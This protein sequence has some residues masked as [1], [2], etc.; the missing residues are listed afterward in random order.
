MLAS[1]CNKRRQEMKQSIAFWLRHF[2]LI[3][4]VSLAALG[5]VAGCAF[6][7][8]YGTVTVGPSATG[9]LKPGDLEAYGIAFITPATVTGQEED[10]PALA[11]IFSQVLEETRPATHIVPLNAT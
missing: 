4:C 10:R 8:K 6:H 1:G 3:G 7:Q 2:V 5:S 11:L 9:P